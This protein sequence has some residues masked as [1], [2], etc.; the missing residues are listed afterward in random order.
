MYDHVAVGGEDGAI[1]L[2]RIGTNDDDKDNNDKK[3]RKGKT[4]GKKTDDDEEEEEEEEEED[5]DEDEDEDK[6]SS[7]AVSP[8]PVIYATM[9]RNPDPSSTGAVRTG[10]SCRIK[11]LQSLG[12]TRVVTA[13][14][15]GVVAI[16]DLQDAIDVIRRDVDKGL[17]AEE[18]DEDD[19]DESDDESDDKANDDA[20]GGTAR[21]LK[22][23]QLGTG[24]RITCMS[25]WS[26][27]DDAKKRDDQE[28]MRLKD[29]Q[30]QRSGKS[31]SKRRA[32]D[33]EEGKDSKK[34][35]NSKDKVSK[36][37]D[38]VVSASSVPFVG[39]GRFLGVGVDPRRTNGAIDLEDEAAMKKARSLVSKAKDLI[40]RK[41]KKLA[42]KDKGDKDKRERN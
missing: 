35:K 42:R 9:A 15:E 11:C 24:A 31:A 34:K 1:M 40:K 22:R 5:D 2:F 37:S 8:P 38:L 30:Q 19:D 14:S 4:P 32:E 3:E 25:V 12:G 26:V 20:N 28:Q 33:E 13:T 21:L 41:E 7:S 39:K 16:W 6:A 36:Q 23:A 18:D 10:A 17:L 27:D 29:E